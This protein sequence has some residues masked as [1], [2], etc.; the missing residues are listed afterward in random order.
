DDYLTKPVKPIIVQSKIRA[1][2]RIAG[3]RNEL[4]KANEKLCQANVELE[5]LSYLDGLT[6]VVNRRGFEKTFL[7][8]WR[9]SQREN[10]PLAVV[11]IDIDEFKKYNDGYGH[12]QGDDCLK[13]VAETLNN[14]VRRPGD[15]VARY[16]GEEFVILLPNTDL[17]GAVYVVSHLVENVR[18]LKIA[19]LYAANNHK[20]TISAGISSTELMSKPYSDEDLLESADKALYIAKESGR[21]RFVVYQPNTKTAHA[22]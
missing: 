15:I 13:K 17:E 14:T 8:E 2:A 18:A 11:M 6:G 10:T 9:R 5:R 19:H 1:M 16:G 21:N 12:L 20:V 7:T 4:S 3:M 22:E